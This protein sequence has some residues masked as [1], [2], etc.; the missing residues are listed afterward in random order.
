MLFMYFLYFNRCKFDEKGSSRNETSDDSTRSFSPKA[1]DDSRDEEQRCEITLAISL[2]GY[3][4]MAIVCGFGLVEVYV[5]FRVATRYLKSWRTWV[6]KDKVHVNATNT[7]FLRKLSV[8]FK[9]LRASLIIMGVTLWPALQFG[10]LYNITWQYPFAAV[11]TNTTG[12]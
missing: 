5:Q 2:A 8:V 6:F 9:V 3:L 11:C 7:S 1:D 10:N 12:R 4:L